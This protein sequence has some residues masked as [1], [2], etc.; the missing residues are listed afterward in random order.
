VN[1]TEF[2]DI[3]GKNLILDYNAVQQ[4]PGNQLRCDQS[5]CKD[6]GLSCVEAHCW[7]F[8]QCDSASLIGAAR[9]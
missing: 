2:L 5:T 7:K 4:G 9:G 8:N 3:E 6:Q 1:G